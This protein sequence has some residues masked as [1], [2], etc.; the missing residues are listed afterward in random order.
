M[1]RGEA[2]LEELSKRIY[3]KPHPKTESYIDN[4]MER[5]R[6]RSK[7]Q[8]NSY[9]TI[10]I[11]SLHLPQMISPSPAP[12]LP[13][14]FPKTPAESANLEAAFLTY[15]I[16]LGV[17]KKKHENPAALPPQ[18]PQT[19]NLNAGMRRSLSWPNQVGHRSLR[20]GSCPQPNRAPQSSQY[21]LPRP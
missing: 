10:F 19:V 7:Q 18:N 20:N 12:A 9:S 1:E 2:K 8:T 3:L 17:E 15:H 4:A 16:S 14:P 21:V 13:S 6:A 5:Y 11:S